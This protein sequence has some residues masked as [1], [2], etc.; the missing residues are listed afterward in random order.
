MPIMQMNQEA[1]GRV[2]YYVAMANVDDKGNLGL[3]NEAAALKGDV[4]YFGPGGE[5][6]DFRSNPSGQ[7]P[8]NYNGV[9]TSSHALANISGLAFDNYN[10]AQKA[11][12]ELVAQHSIKVNNNYSK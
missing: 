5:K 7:A 3:W 8:T 11:Y 9:A 4:T 6:Q 2:Q 12:Y 10:D 1:N